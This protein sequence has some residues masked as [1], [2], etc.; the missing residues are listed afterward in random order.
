MRIAKVSRYWWVLRQNAAISRRTSSKYAEKTGLYISDQGN[1]EMLMIF[2]SMRYRYLWMGDKKRLG[3]WK[4]LLGRQL[5]KRKRWFK[6]ILRSSL[7]NLSK[8]YQNFTRKTKM[9]KSAT[10]QPYS[11]DSTK[12]LRKVIKKWSSNRPKSSSAVGIQLLKHL[13]QPKKSP[14]KSH[15]LASQHL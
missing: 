8:A 6:R 1:S 5:G 3:N 14:S 4:N 10:N 15:H 12:F 7:C 2:R 13:S 9:S 11:P